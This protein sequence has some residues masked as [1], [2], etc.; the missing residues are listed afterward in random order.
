M[1][2][3]CVVLPGLGA[4]VAQ[5]E[6][7]SLSADGTTLTPPSRLVAFNSDLRHD[8]GLLAAS[9]SRREHVGYESARTIV[10]NEIA[11]L[12]SRLSSSGFAVMP[13]IGKLTRH[14]SSLLFAPHA[15]LLMLAGWQYRGLQSVLLTPAAM[16]SA[17]DETTF[18]AAKTDAK[19]QYV[20]SVDLSRRRRRWMRVAASV[21]VMLALGAAVTTP[22]AVDNSKMQFASLAGL[23]VKGAQ[24]AQL[25][26]QEES[27]K[28]DA[29]LWLA[30]PADA[31]AVG[32][33]EH[34]AVTP[35][36]VNYAP[37]MSNYL[38]VASCETRAKALRW[39]SRH[40]SAG[41]KL[42]E[43]DGRHRVYVAAS[44]NRAELEAM[45]TPELESRYPGAWI[46]SL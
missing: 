9:V 33:Y 4:L 35:A 13:G 2:H 45:R 32:H 37:R 44:N 26:A 15:D 29:T 25:P 43:Y 31:D 18:V 12:K 40:K 5:H 23:H 3:D 34:K 17:G 14:G 27:V 46:F 30:A 8:D 38:I 21:V 36:E 16:V 28:P 19:Q 42:V 41:L 1:H 6:T 11:M 7:A 22:I 20:L 10:A 39:I 24:T